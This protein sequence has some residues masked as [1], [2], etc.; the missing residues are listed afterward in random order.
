MKRKDLVPLSETMHY[1]LLSVRKPLHGY[2]MMQWVLEKSEQEVNLAAGTLYGAIE[3]LKKNGY[4]ELISPQ[5]ERK[6]VYQITKLGEEIL[7]KENERL[8]RIVNIYESGS[9]D[10]HD[11]N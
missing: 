4:I 8:K 1:I 11:N 6:K 5:N 2:G 9:G 3:N 7:F 10:I